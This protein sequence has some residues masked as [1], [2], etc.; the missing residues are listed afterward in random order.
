MKFQETPIKKNCDKQEKYRKK[1]RDSSL[2]PIK[3]SNV[4]RIELPSP[5]K[6]I[7]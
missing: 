3:D 1:G 4:K 2:S 5:A 6:R 7:Q